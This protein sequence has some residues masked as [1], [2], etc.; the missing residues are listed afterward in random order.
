[1][2][3]APTL[4]DSY[5]LAEAQAL[6]DVKCCEVLIGVAVDSVR[7]VSRINCQQRSNVRVRQV[8]IIIDSDDDRS[9][10]GVGHGDYV[11]DQL[12]PILFRLRIEGRL[13]IERS[14]FS[15]EGVKI[16]CHGEGRL[17]R[18]AYNGGARRAVE[19]VLEDAKRLRDDGFGESKVDLTIGGEVEKLFR[20]ASE[21]QCADKNV[22]VSDDALH[23]RVRDS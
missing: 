4:D 10:A 23:E 6:N 7:Y 20:L 8:P 17:D 5:G 21:L 22:R 1:M 18:S 19:L 9:A 15:V 11:L 14:R 2:R 13:E 3:D 12:T 16:D